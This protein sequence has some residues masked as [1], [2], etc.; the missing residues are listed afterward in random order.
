MCSKVQAQDVS[1]E[2]HRSQIHQAEKHARHSL[3]SR[4]EKYIEWGLSVKVEWTAFLWCFREQQLEELMEKLEI[5]GQ[6]RE[7]LA[8]H[9]ALLEKAIIARD[10]VSADFKEAKTAGGGSY[11]LEEP[12]VCCIQSSLLY[13]VVYEEDEKGKRSAAPEHATGQGAYC[14]G[15][16]LC[17][18]HQNQSHRRGQL[19]PAERKV[20]H[21]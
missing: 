7:Q 3:T 14:P 9:N 13:I 11:G 1:E 19:W 20:L 15:Q 12:K 4:K 8:R 21:M 16:G 10:R 17:I 6:E 2:H 5:A 18:L